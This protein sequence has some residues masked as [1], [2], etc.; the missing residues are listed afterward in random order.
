MLENFGLQLI[1]ITKSFKSSNLYNLVT[2]FS[3]LLMN[4]Q[5]EHNIHT[6]SVYQICFY[7]L[8]TY[9]LAMNKYNV[10]MESYYY[11]IHGNAIVTVTHRGQTSE[12][13]F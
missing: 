13:S 10:K 9:K 6:A 5:E 2:V 4:D 7:L 11:L 8:R 1:E 3:S 12:I